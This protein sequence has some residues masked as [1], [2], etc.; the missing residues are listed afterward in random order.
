MQQQ[1]LKGLT[2]MLKE[3][4]L[5]VKCHQTASHT[6]EKSFMK[7]RVDQCGKLHCCLILRNCHSHPNLQQPSE[8][9]Y[10]ASNHGGKPSTWKQDPPPAK[11]LQLMLVKLKTI[12]PRTVICE[13]A[14]LDSTKGIKELIFEVNKMDST[15]SFYSHQDI[16]K[17]LWNSE[18]TLRKLGTTLT[19]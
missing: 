19:Q 5:W 12:S 1:S 14:L 2:P 15:E 6:A 9:Q 11:R 4:L 3:V 8:H 10:G 13:C 7:K 17:E 18:S 16:S